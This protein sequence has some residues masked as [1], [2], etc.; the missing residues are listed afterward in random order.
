MEKDHFSCGTNANGAIELTS[1][2]ITGSSTFGDQPQPYY[3][4]HAQL[5]DLLGSAH[6][7][8]TLRVICRLSLILLSWSLTKF[9][10]IATFTSV[11]PPPSELSSFT[12]MEA[13][14]KFL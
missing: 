1:V 14:K 13:G 10:T 8:V 6:P 3:C 9:P 4:F 7:T 12:L 11:H 2:T 5:K